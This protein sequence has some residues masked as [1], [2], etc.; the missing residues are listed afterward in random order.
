[1]A[2]I[3]KKTGNV[4]ADVPLLL[5]SVN[6]LSDPRM[7]LF[8]RSAVTEGDYGAV[9]DAHALAKSLVPPGSELWAWWLDGVESLARSGDQDVG[10]FV[11]FT[12]D[13]AGIAPWGSLPADA[14]E[15]LGALGG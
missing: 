11:R 3:G 10:L 13:V 12:R 8:V 15:R 14:R 5:D 4:P 9:Q 7:R 1:M 2:L 6:P